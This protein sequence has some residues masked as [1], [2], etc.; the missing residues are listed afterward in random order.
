MHGLTSGFMLIRREAEM[1]HET[2][3]RCSRCH[4]DTQLRTIA[5]GESDNVLTGIYQC[6]ECGHIET[7]D[8]SLMPTPAMPGPDRHWPG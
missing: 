5:S 6:P 8:N 2:K 3:Q 7:R 4:N 1:E